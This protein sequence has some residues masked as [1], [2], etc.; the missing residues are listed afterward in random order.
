MNLFIVAFFLILTGCSPSLYQSEYLQKLYG[1]ESVKPRILSN[2]ELAAVDSGSKISFQHSVKPILDARCVVCHGCFDAP[3]QLKLGSIEG[4]DRGASKQNIY[5]ARLSAVPPTR[6]FTDAKNTTEWRQKNFSPV[7]NERE[8]TMMANRSNALLAKLLDL[9]RQHPLPASGK[10]SADYDL[11]FDRELQCPTIA[12]FPDYQSEH[13]D[14]GMPYAFPGLSQ[15]DEN[16]LMQWLQEGGRAEPLPALSGLAQLEIGK[17]ERYFN[18]SS[19]KQ[20]LVARYLFEHLFI[21]HIHFKGHPQNEFYQWVRSTTPPGQAINEIPSVR[22]YDD[23][24]T[25]DFFY[26]LRRVSE[27][28]V[29]KIHFVY[30]LSDAKMHRYDDLFFK[31]EYT[32]TELPT[33]QPVVSSNPF[34]AF[35]ALPLTSRYQ[36]LLDDAQY[37]VSGFIKGPVC[38]GQAATGSIRDRFWVIFTKPGLVEGQKVNQA[39]AE[40][41]AILGLPGEEA[42]SIGLF[43]WTKYDEFGREYIAKKNAFLGQVLPKGR[44]Y[45]LQHIWD[46]GGS[47]P[48]AALTIFRH[49]DSATV[50]QGFI[51]TIPHTAWV[52]D[53]P[54]FERLHYL[55]VAGFNVFGNAGHQLASR[56]Y[57]DIIRQDAEDNFLRFMPSGQRYRIYKSWYPGVTSLRAVDPLYNVEHESLVEFKTTD[58]IGEFLQQVR[59]RLGA[60][61]GTYDALNACAQNN[62]DNQGGSPLKQTIDA[63][64]RQLANIRGMALS[65]LP[66]M[67]L[68]RIKTANPD[69]DLVYTLLADRYYNNISQ[70]I[71]QD[72]RRIPEMDTLTVA[73]GFIGSYPNFFFSV[74][75]NQ[76]ADFIRLLENSQD[77]KS[78]EELYSRFG[79]RRTHPD[80]WQTSDWFND[81]HQIY[82]GLE[83]GFLDLNRYGNF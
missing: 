42:D 10:L 38:R 27:T 70:M 31:P 41:N 45:G 39:L 40:N 66:E 50:V 57:M 58:Y 75:Q 11:E 30:E 19:L 1:P 69:Q 9:K 23:P 21:G 61:A 16:T 36:F 63:Q 52:V 55:L 25:P 83:A 5:D 6:L 32:V 81:Q 44:G 8:D 67:A 3:C 76:L 17:W 77:E 53:F 15:Q 33:Y 14:W 64:M 47:N 12:E 28:L 80:F 34:A 74:E 78:R 68:L 22:P 71:W 35:S 43:G 54:M 51:G 82:R 48:N 49:Q 56:T 13:P 62:C 60:A 24:G 26:R 2:A 65:A 46:G 59:Q 4:M 29:D 20:K 73:P 72:S 18:A 79:I 37:F 7:L